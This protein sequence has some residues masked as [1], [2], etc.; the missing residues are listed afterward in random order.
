MSAEDDNIVKLSEL[1]SERPDP[2]F[3]GLMLNDRKQPIPNLF[4]AERLLRREMPDH[5]AYNEMLR[6]AVLFRPLNDDEKDF[7]RGRPLTDVDVDFVQRMLQELGLKHVGKDPARSAVDMLAERF[8]FHPVRDYLDKLR[9]DEVPRVNGL[10]PRYFGAEPSP[11]VNAVSR[12]FLISMVARIFEPGCKVDHMPVLEGDQGGFKSMAC[13]ILAGE[14]F[15][16]HLPDITL[17]DASQH[18]RGK[19]LIEVGE[20]HVMTRAESAALKAFITRQV[21][22]YRPSYGRCEVHEKRQCAFIGTTNKEVYLKDETG[23]RRFWPLKCGEVDVDALRR[24]RD[25]LFAEAS[26]LYRA[27]VPWWPDKQFEQQHMM[28]EQETRYETDA[29]EEKIAEHLSTMSETTIGEVA[30]QA[31]FFETRCIGKADQNR[32]TVVMQ[33]LHWHRARKRGTGGARLWTRD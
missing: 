2:A 17:K 33:R 15:S 20:M 24:D 9:W 12:M 16:D 28:P 14:W 18:L 13:A 19:W 10:F 29:W 21:E 6:A 1:M 30:R 32:I 8:K 23:N 4:N 11:Y 26:A 5:F 25:Q 31:L 7:M 3:S 22:R 27:G